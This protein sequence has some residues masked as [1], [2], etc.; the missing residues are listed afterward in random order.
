MKPLSLE[1]TAF[2]SYS[3]KTVISFENFNDGL[4]LITGDTG[5]GK[6]TIFDGIV[7]ALYGEL[8][9]SDK[10][11]RKPDMMHCDQ[12]SKAVDT[13]VSLRFRQ[14]GKE[15]KVSR[16][17]HFAKRRGSEDEYRAAPPIAV[18]YE[19]DDVVTEGSDKVT[20][21][22]TELLGLNKDQ[23]R[24]IV[25]LAQGEFREFLRAD[26]GKKSDILGKLFDNSAYTR[27]EN[28][29]SQA[30]D[31]LLKKREASDM[32]VRNQMEQVFQRP[33]DLDSEEMLKFL[34]T[35]PELV[36]NLERLIERE[37]K[38]LSELKKKRDRSNEVLNKLSAKKGQAEETNKRI[39]ELSD[40][41]EEAEILN[42]EKPEKEKLRI[43]SRNCEKIMQDILPLKRIENEAGKR[44]KQVCEEIDEYS[45][46]KENKEKELLEADNVLKAD[47]SEKLKYQ[48]YQTEISTLM[49]SL[50]KYDEL[51][52]KRNS[53]KNL[54]SEGCRLKEKLKGLN[55]K[56]EEDLRNIREAETEIEKLQD[57]ELN[58]S[59][60]TQTLSE[61][62]AAIADAGEIG[63]E[64]AE[65]R[66]LEKRH[67]EC[68][69]E[70]QRISEEAIRLSDIYNTKYK[71]F[72]SAQAGI[73]GESL[74]R[75]LSDKGEALCPV[76]R[77]H[78]IKGQEHKFAGLEDGAPT[79]KDVDDA[80]SDSEQKEKERR[81]KE[82]EKSTLE[83]GIKTRQKNIVERTRKRFD[84]CTD[85]KVLS[86]DG[87]L[88]KKIEELNVEKEACSKALTT[89][90]EQVLRKTSLKELVMKKREE[91][92]KILLDTKDTEQQVQENSVNS[93]SLQ[94]DISS[95]E[96]NLKFT[97]KS[98]V[99][100]KISELKELCTAISERLKKH[101]EDRQAVYDAYNENSTK[102]N[103]RL[104]KKPELEVEVKDAG[105]ALYEALGN[106]GY[107]DWGDA[108]AVLRET[109]TSNIS[110]WI[111][112]TNKDLI[113][114]DKNYA[115]CMKRID[116]L[117]VETKDTVYVD[118]EE[119]NLQISEQ[120]NTFEED[121]TE[122]NV[123]AGLISNH[124]SVLSVVC[125]KRAEQSA[126]DRPWK[127]ISKLADL[128]GGSN[129]EGGQLS[130]NRYV[131]GAAFQE[132][133]ERANQRLEIMSG[134]RY[135]LE[136]KINAGRKNGKAGLEIEI[137][138]YSTGQRRDS[139][140]L[141]GGE[142][143]MSSMSLALGLSD[144]VQSHA[145]GTELDTLF[146]D[147]GFGSL[148][149]G[150]L[151][152]AVEVLNNLT[153]DNN[154]LVG[155]ISHID[156]LQESIAQKIIVR[157][158]DGKSRVEMIG[159]VK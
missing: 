23:F 33:D 135:S 12:V 108:E 107:S 80:K 114:F 127:L 113:E 13:E 94:G 120:R 97:D 9:G 11:D 149:S 2:G 138:D 58:E 36:S 77:T 95:I 37:D 93:A 25:M 3:D 41:K 49:D 90:Q 158:Q 14:S 22:C 124:R 131:M 87:Y 1:M 103:D 133:L 46:L 96:N 50:P 76:C 43:L 19:P 139:A 116:E 74:E 98:A 104:K 106:A 35:E 59:K 44:L 134:G 155:I 30:K 141:S 112:D 83:T 153:E 115:V 110:E 26:S 156:R 42:S 57:A 62:E 100:G 128:A 66:E 89:A 71:F 55:D 69:A 45:L 61:S 132:I 10:A 99:E 81:E 82:N 118:L 88:Q 4:F 78:F 60:Y 146:I 159:S 52:K 84:D 91:H 20:T 145:G 150:V 63:K 130:F 143:F 86:S 121:N 32:A 144:V 148:D 40:R 51:Q 92:E 8:S 72:I 73:I 16:K 67:E 15:Y 129:A 27:Y 21:R 157:N 154:H 18:L 34:P 65:I 137:M 102:V 29:L 140:S 56:A 109:G 119:L 105:E 117:N 111:V 75:E 38:W 126:T 79:K 68:R 85:W 70:L 7:F 53:L 5:A 123:Q 24:Q 47:E 122:M 142:T 54:E 151:D 39:K 125:E 17:I 152:K 31:R 48:Q 147:E 101:E 28:L 64:V 6:T 136:H